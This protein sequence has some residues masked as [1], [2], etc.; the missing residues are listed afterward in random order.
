MRFKKTEVCQTCAKLKNACQ[1]C[2]L[3]LE[4]GLPLQV[5]DQALGI[6]EAMPTSDVN[7]EYYTQ[8]QERYADNVVHNQGRVPTPA[9]E[10]FYEDTE[11]VRARE[12][13]RGNERGGEC[14]LM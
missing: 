14:M 10:P 7:R 2:L 12:R 11:R 8:N 9:C 5:R 3:D 1:T 6:D 13:A 4:Y